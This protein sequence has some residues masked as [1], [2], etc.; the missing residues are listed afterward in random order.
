MP[1]PVVVQCPSCQARLQVTPD[2]LGQTFACPMCGQP[3][4]PT[5]APL[6][7]GA[8]PPALP[9]QSVGYAGPVQREPTS[10]MAIASL[11]FGILFCFPLFSVLALIF[12]IIGINKTA[13]GRAQGRGMA[14]AGTVLGGVGLLFMFPLMISILLPSLNRA[15]E[16]ANRA[17]CASNM[18]QVGLAILLYQQD[19]RQQYPPDLTTLCQT[20]QLPLSTLVCPSSNDTPAASP[21]QLSSGGHLSYV[22]VPPGDTPS[23]ANTP[24]LYEKL[25]D[26]SNDG[27]NILFGDGHVSW[28]TAAAAKTLLGTP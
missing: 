25:T 28:F 1:E 14:I 6:V 7:G 27:T 22:Y 15:R 24:V 17:K 16:V 20:E 18:H 3:F 12:G 26:H 10:G 11:V 2:K 21:A 9:P 23:A 4:Q 19:N 8:M 13:P 5:A